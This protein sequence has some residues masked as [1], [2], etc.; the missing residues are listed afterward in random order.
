[1]E[2]IR[3]NGSSSYN[4]IIKRDSIS[5]AGEHIKEVAPTATKALIVTDERVC[6]LYGNKVEDSIKSVGL[7]T[8]RH[9]IKACCEQN[10]NII[11]VE[12]IYDRA[13]AFMLSR[14]DII[15]ALGGGIV[16]DTAGFAAATY[17]RG[18]NF[19]QV[20][21]TLTAQTDSSVGGKCG[22]NYG[23]IKN[24][25]GAFYN[26]VLVYVDPETL[27]TLPPREFSAGMAEVIK[28]GC[29][30]DG[31]LFTLLESGSFDIA[32]IISRCIKIKR[33]I[34]IN[35]ERDMGLRHILNYGHTIGHAA[36]EC[37][38]NA[39]LHGEGVAAGM[40]VMAEIGERIGITETDTA[41][42]IRALCRKYSL[43]VDVSQYP[44]ITDYLCLD[45]K[46]TDNCIKA[47][48]VTK[49]GECIVKSININKL[50]EL[51]HG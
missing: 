41:K 27:T 32:D 31:E 1:M 16:G 7:S 15:I 49:I 14:N 25:I 26:P 4:I 8:Q 42:R 24:L 43:P 3:I 18:I 46:R 37:T 38:K 34:V 13:M 23:G 11:E 36:E 51:I 22:I 12:K 17:M 45:K 28:Y 9:I 19:V 29:I 20:P 48:F 47:V 30:A 33:D 35:D 21:T 44:N 50:S 10:K 5:E 2:T 6:E 40:C 39:V